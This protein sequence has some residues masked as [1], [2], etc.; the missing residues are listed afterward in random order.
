MALSEALKDADKK[1]KKEK[2]KK[3]KTFSEKFA[4]SLGG[5]GLKGRTTLPPDRSR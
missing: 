3:K 4:E 5:K 2:K 1:K